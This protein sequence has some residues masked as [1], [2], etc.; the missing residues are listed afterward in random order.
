MKSKGVQ[1]RKCEYP[2][3]PNY[4]PLNTVRGKHTPKRWCYHHLDGAGEAERREYS[5]TVTL[6][7][8]NY[9]HGMKHTRQYGIW[10]AMKARCN[11]KTTI[12]Y[13]YYGGKGITYDPRWNKFLPFWEDMKEG[14]AD[15][16]TIDRIDGT[17]GYYKENCRWIT[18]QEQQKN[19]VKNKAFC[20]IVGIA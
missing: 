19:K 2:E 16:L 17:K 18:I 13:K 5:K 6:K 15:N 3:C 8:S 7:N 1:K 4:T 9:R 11:R 14:Y 20:E 12:N 10:L